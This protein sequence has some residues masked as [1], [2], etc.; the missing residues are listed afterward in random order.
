MK[1]YVCNYKIKQTK[2]LSI[3][4]KEK[5]QKQTKTNKKSQKQKNVTFASTI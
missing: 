1:E 5:K 4:S 3:F 2:N